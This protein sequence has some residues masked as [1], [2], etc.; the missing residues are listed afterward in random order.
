MGAE[1]S[2][3]DATLTIQDVTILIKQISLKQPMIFT[4]MKGSFD[5]S[6]WK[7]SNYW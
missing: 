3:T 5:W 7:Q 1:L 4:L 6:R 2:A